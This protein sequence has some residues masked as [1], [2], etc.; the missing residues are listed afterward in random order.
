MQ[1]QV[2]FFG[3]NGMFWTGTKKVAQ[4][5]DLNHVFDFFNP[6]KIRKNFLKIFYRTKKTDKHFGKILEKSRKN[7]FAA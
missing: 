1:Y 5:S 6:G 4:V 7:F 3:I 2:I